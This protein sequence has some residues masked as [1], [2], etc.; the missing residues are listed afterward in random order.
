MENEKNKKKGG[1]IYEISGI[2]YPSLYICVFYIYIYMSLN[3]IL[4]I[5]IAQRD[6]SDLICRKKKI[7]KLK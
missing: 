6:D 7:F 2:A 1:K 5:Y 3:R 4:Y